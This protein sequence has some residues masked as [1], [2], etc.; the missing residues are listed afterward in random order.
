MERCFPNLS[1]FQKDLD[2]EICRSKNPS[3]ASPHF[4]QH[5]RTIKN[6]STR[7]AKHIQSLSRK[8]K[9]MSAA[10]KLAKDVYIVAAKRTPFGTYGGVLKDMTPTQ[11]G[12]VAAEAAFTQAGLSPEAV[13]S[14]IVGNVAQTAA[15][16]SYLARHVGLKAGVPIDRPALTV[17]RLCGSGFQSIVNGTQEI[18]CGDAEVV[19]TGGAESMSSAPFSARSM[20]FGTKLFTDVPLKETIGE[21]LFDMHAGCPMVRRGEGGKGDLLCVVPASRRLLLLSA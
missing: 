13:D 21:S 6:L 14:V 3:R 5:S 12:V 7:T 1:Q 20:R 10:R 15:D 17:N 11:L 8:R 4:D 9:T 2:F 16:T 19:L 18:L